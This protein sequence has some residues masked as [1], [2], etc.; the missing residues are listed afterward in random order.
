MPYMFGWH[1][2]FKVNGN[3]KDGMFE[4]VDSDGIKQYRLE[5]LISDVSQAKG[6]ILIA[7]SDYIAYGNKSTGIGFYLDA[8]NF[9]N[10]MLWSPGKD[11]GMFCIEPVTQIPVDPKKQAYFTDGK[12]ESLKPS[13]RKDYSITITPFN[14]TSKRR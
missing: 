10:F 3:S 8:R 7:D 1:P 11:A 13:S 6:P 9:G 14:Q 5:E 12:F 4:I 2:A